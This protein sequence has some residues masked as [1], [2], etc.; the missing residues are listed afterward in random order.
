MT[1][2][3]TITETASLSPEE[4]APAPTATM[5]ESS[6]SGTY[7]QEIHRDTSFQESPV[8]STPG[9]TVHESPM[10]S[11]PGV[12][13]HES[14]LSSNP[15][16]DN[17]KDETVAHAQSGEPT[18]DKGD[19]SVTH[20][21]AAEPAHANEDSST[22]HSPNSAPA[23]NPIPLHDALRMSP[24]RDSPKAP[25]QTSQRSDIEATPQQVTVPLDSPVSANQETARV[26]HPQ[27]HQAPQGTHV[28]QLVYLHQQQDI[29]SKPTPRTIVAVPPK[30][31]SAGSKSSKS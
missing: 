15:E 5:P 4:H 1:E 23:N 17:L 25:Y 22:A 11:N 21:S 28:S 20:A 26:A 9:V 31:V 16:G 3:A 10:S 19:D 18:Q 12:T 7:I 27:H 2:S 6:G 29:L 13:I 14:P 8:P 24:S 30:K